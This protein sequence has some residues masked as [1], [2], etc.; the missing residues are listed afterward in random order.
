MAEFNERRH[1][2][3]VV[4]NGNISV[5][6]VPAGQSLRLIDVGIGG[7]R[8]ESAEALRPDLV[9]NYRF[10]TP[11]KKWSGLFRARTV[12][13]QPAPSDDP[14]V[15]KYVSG[16]SFLNTESETVQRELMTL[17]D[18]ATAFMSFS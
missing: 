8:V 1:T 16:F 17:M 13:S 11:D 2:V 12:Y 6:T 7:F 10:V 5:E 9:T 18:H 14:A 15:R 4:V 3:R